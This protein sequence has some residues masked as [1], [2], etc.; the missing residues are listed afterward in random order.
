VVPP[1]ISFMVLNET[2]QKVIQC[3]AANSKPAAKIT[4]NLPGNLPKEI[5]YN[6]TFQNGTYTAISAFRLP[7]YLP[8]E[9]N[10]TCVIEHPALHDPETRTIHIPPCF[11]PHITVRSVTQ[12]KKDKECTTVECVATTSK[13][14]ANA[15]FLLTYILGKP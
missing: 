6:S 8:E 11:P 10:V 12:N 9:H 1:N 14:A 13:P 5:M 2:E 15:H 3:I 7:A 4:W